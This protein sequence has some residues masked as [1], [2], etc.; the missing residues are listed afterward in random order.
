MGGGAMFSPASL[1]LDGRR[2]RLSCILTA[3]GAKAAF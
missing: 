3:P 1:G 2:E